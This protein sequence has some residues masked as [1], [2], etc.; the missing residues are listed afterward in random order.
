[1]HSDGRVGEQETRLQV[2]VLDHADE[3]AWGGIEGVVLTEER[4]ERALV[5]TDWLTD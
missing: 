2:I 5:P 1:M 3:E 4:Y